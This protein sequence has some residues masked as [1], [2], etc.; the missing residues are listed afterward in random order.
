MRRLPVVSALLAGVMTMTAQSV[1]PAIMEYT[2]AAS[3]QFE[4][5][6]DSPLP[7]VVTMEAKSFTID[8]RGVGHFMPLQSSIHLQLSQT[9]MKLPPHGHRAVFYKATADAYPAW[10]CIYSAFTGLPKR[11]AMNVLL[12]L[13]HTVYLLNKSGANSEDIQFH[14]L[15]VEHGEL[16][17]TVEN[18]SANVVRLQSLQWMNRD[19][20]KNEAGG[21]PLLPGGVRALNIALPVDAEPRHVRARMGKLSIDGDVR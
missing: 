15:R 19:G 14:A 1:R 9:S 3:G 7:L 20:K 11:G 13:P 12:E 2:S 8:E 5:V 16:I 21:F 18:R 4:L 6:N 17:G 10:F